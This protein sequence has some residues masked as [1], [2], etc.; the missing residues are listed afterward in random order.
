MKQNLKHVRKRRIYSDEFKRQIV[1]YFESGNYSVPQLERLYNI[2]TPTIYR[3]IYSFS[4]FNK[5]GQRVVEMKDSHTQRLKELEH[6]VRELELLV[7]QKQVKIE[8]L[9]KMIDVASSEYGM[10]IKKNSGTPHSTSSARAGK[11]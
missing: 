8:Y 9:E 5:K 6:K 2:R 3:W 1:G 11:G 10:D 7:G 4:T